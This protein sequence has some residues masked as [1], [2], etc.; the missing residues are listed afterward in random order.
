MRVEARKADRP[1][2]AAIA[3]VCALALL[4][5]V[6]ARA[7]APMHGTVVSEDGQPIADVNVSGSPPEA[8]PYKRDVTKTDA[9]GRF[10]LDHPGAVVHFFKETFE[11]LTIITAQ[12]RSQTQF[13]LPTAKNDLVVPPCGPVPAGSRRLDGGIR[14][15]FVVNLKTVKIL[16]GKTDV[17]YRKYV[18]KPKSPKDSKAYLALWFGPYAFEAEPFDDDLIQSQRFSQRNLVLASGG[19]IGIDTV[20]AKNGLR[21]RH[22]GGLGNGADYDLANDDEARLFDEIV[23]SIC[24]ADPNVASH[25]TK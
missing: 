13:V 2:V 25:S 11:P 10:I 6:P 18:I 21:W 23:N 19:A 17:D 1:A 16:G 4:C 12:A 20:G 7:Q 24:M 14:L 5:A 8:S 22:T 15:Q 3:V 9:T